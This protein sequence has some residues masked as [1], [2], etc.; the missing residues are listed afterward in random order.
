MSDNES[1]EVKE[2]PIKIKPPRREI[3]PSNK[4][5]KVFLDNTQMLSLISSINANEDSQVDKKLER[6]GKTEVLNNERKKKMEL[7]ANEKQAHLETVKNSLRKKRKRHTKGE[8]A[9]SASAGVAEDKNSKKV[10]FA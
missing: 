9:V 4:K 6:M 3:K 7:R 10:S 8:D 1:V 2:K 5:Q